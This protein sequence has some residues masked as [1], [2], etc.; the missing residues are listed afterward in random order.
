MAE[1][2]KKQKIDLQGRLTRLKKYSLIFNV[3]FSRLYEAMSTNAVGG[4]LVSTPEMSSLGAIGSRMHI[5]A[6][7]FAL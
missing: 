7:Q 6:Q 1:L 4:C 2:N 3:H 5:R